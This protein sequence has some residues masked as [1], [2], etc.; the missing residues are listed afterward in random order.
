MG[1]LACM[2]LPLEGEWWAR[3]CTVH[4][5]LSLLTQQ[6]KR[7][8]WSLLSVCKFLYVSVGQA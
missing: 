5:Y 6:D 7:Y 1:G 4:Q 3:A 8:H 2:Q